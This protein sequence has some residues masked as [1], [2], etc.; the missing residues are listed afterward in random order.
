MP[1]AQVE[2]V[3]AGGIQTFTLP[4]GTAFTSGIRKQPQLGPV[5]VGRD[6]IEG[7]AQHLDVHGG[8]DREIHAFCREHYT[9]FEAI[10]GRPLPVPLV[11]ENLTL[12][13]Y[14]DAD[15]RVGDVLRIGTTRLQ[16]TMPTERCA[17]PGRVH[18][19]PKLLKWMI[20]SLRTGFYLRVLEPGE[21]IPG[22]ALVLEQQ[23]DARW[24]IEALSR[25]M[26]QQT[27]DAALAAALRAVP[28]LAPAWKERFEVLH[29]RRRVAAS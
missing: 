1:V 16:V 14:S 29:E 19:V 13:G 2:S 3:N 27:D 15:A 23:G 12:R 11:G 5:S 7:D 10:H 28:E 9:H 21:I 26:Y 18:A 17:N 4:D 24:T 25:A 8:L 22:D 20:E 6:G